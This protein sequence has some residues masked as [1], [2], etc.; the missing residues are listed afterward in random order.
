MLAHY[1]AVALAKFRKAPLTTT[2]NILTLALGLACFVAAWGIADYWRSSDGYHPNADRLFFVSQGFRQANR[3]QAGV[4]PPTTYSSPRLAGDLRE[5]IPELEA[6]ARIAGGVE[7]SVSVEGEESF[8]QFATADPEIFDLLSFEFIEGD[9]MTALRQPED[10]ILVETAAR[11]LFGDEPALG[12]RLLVNNAWDA[13]VVGVIA[14]VRQPSF[15]GHGDQAPLSFEAIGQHEY[16]TRDTPPAMKESYGVLGPTTIVRLPPTLSREAF[17]AR[18]DDLVDRR[19]PKGPDGTSNLSMTPV[20]VMS[21]TTEMI[22]RQFLSNNTFGVS[23]VVLLPALGALILAIAAVNY[24]NLATTQALARAKEVGMRAALG[25]RRVDVLAQH[26]LEAALTTFAALALALAAVAATAPVVRSQLEVDILRF[27][28]AGAGGALFLLAVALATSVAASLYPALTLLRIRPA[29]ALGAGRRIS[30]SLAGK[31]FVGLQFLSASFLLIMVTVMN[32]QQDWLRE[33]AVGS[34]RAPVVV[35]GL[36][37]RSGVDF[38]T[39]AARLSSYPQIETTTLLNFPPWTESGIVT[40]FSLSDDPNAADPASAIWLKTVSHDYF[41]TFSQ[42]LIA[43]RVFSREQETAPSPLNQALPGDPVPIVID[44]NA[45]RRL[46]FATAQAAVGAVIHQRSQGPDPNAPRVTRP[47]EIIGVVETD[48]TRLG[49]GPSGAVYQFD[50]VM[51]QSAR[52]PAI[53]VARDDI[54]GAVAAI[55]RV[56]S[57]LSPDVPLSA[58]LYGDLFERG[59]APFKRVKSTV[60]GLS[61]CAFIIA[62]TGLLGVAAHAAAR[63]RHEIGVRKTLGSS[64]LGIVRLLLVDFARPAL[65]ANLI[66]WPLSY[67]AAQAYLSAFSERIALTPAPFL[68]SMAITLSIAW[69]AVIGEVWKAASLRPAEVLRHV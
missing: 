2:A 68:L 63:R 12:K 44:E 29:E 40:G 65:A 58:D 62:T 43:G 42:G 14:P 1:L 57:E 7:A 5:D 23:V 15:L 28:T 60:T 34:D 4:A 41:T 38:D 50:P 33:R 59:M 19:A 25:A 39:L 26:W 53:R 67:L 35:L 24:A 30:S 61:L 51:A 64:T 46:G 9:P 6:V 18:L 56:W 21:L 17:A 13:R 54:P 16:A 8:L 55:E 48:I 31:F 69:A 66:A 22:D 3:N 20:P 49:A 37:N 36:L 45:A 32:L 11:R 10:I 52:L 27:L 47:A